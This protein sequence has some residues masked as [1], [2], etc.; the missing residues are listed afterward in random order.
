MIDVGKATSL[1]EWKEDYEN[2]KITKGN[3]I[4]YQ[5]ILNKERY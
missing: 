3:V 1:I 2:V 5:Q 4:F